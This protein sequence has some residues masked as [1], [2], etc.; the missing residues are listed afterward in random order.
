M[1]RERRKA[2]LA[3]LMATEYATARA[4][5]PA[6]SGREFEALPK[7]EPNNQGARM[8]R[9]A[10]LGRNSRHLPKECRTTKERGWRWYGRL[11]R[12]VRVSSALN[13]CVATVV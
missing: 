7:G 11:A 5:T 13:E 6:A 8:A 1:P 2:V 10:M 3:R 4:R 12:S 9:C